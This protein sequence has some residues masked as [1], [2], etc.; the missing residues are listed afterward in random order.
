M[1]I[2][3]LIYHESNAI[4]SGYCSLI[5]YGD[6]PDIL[7]QINIIYKKSKIHTY[8]VAIFTITVIKMTSDML[9]ITVNMMAVDDNLYHH[10]LLIFFFNFNCFV[11]S[12]K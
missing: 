9:N 10:I 3:R 2:K 4:S 1:Q 6:L 5:V 8:I 11:F 12:G 7:Q